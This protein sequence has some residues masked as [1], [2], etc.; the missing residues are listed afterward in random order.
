MEDQLATSSSEDATNFL[1]HDF[2]N[3]RESLNQ[4]SSRFESSTRDNL[5][6]CLETGKF[7]SMKH[8]LSHSFFCGNSQ[9]IIVYGESLQLLIYGFSACRIPLTNLVRPLTW[10]QIVSKVIAQPSKVFTLQE[11]GTEIFGETLITQ[12]PIHNSSQILVIIPIVKPLS[13]S[14]SL[15]KISA[16][17]EEVFYSHCLELMN[18]ISFD[19]SRM[20][21]L[22]DL[23]VKIKIISSI[24]F[25]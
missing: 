3:L 20:L 10:N 17:C 7:K 12:I 8:V 25:F 22:H 18:W 13:S 16:F 9:N 21:I 24:F 19:F 5:I 1:D 11:N 14:S 15:G 6:M 2:A 23:T 4:L